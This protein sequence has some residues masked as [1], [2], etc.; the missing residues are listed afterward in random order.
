MVNVYCSLGVADVVVVVAAVVVVVVSEGAGAAVVVVVGT[1]VVVSGFEEAMNVT[2]FVGILNECVGDCNVAESVFQFD[3]I[4]P[5]LV[6]AFTVTLEP[7][8]IVKVFIS[9]VIFAF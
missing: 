9:L 8:G 6:L 7:S 4:Y 1:V 5:A 2:V 3:H